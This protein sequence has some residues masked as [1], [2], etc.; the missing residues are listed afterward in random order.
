MA[1]DPNVPTTLGLDAWLARLAEP[2]GAP[3]GGSAAGVMLGLSAALL[4]MVCAYTPDDEAAAAS[5]ERVS[6]LR[7]RSLEAGR[8]DGVRSVELGAALASDGPDRSA[9]LREKAVAGAGSSAA[10]GE[11][12]LALVDELVVIA[13][14]GNPS[15]VADTGVAGE[16]LRAGLG[17]ALINLRAN[18][19]LAR[20]HSG[21]DDSSADIDE[22]AAAG[23][24][25][26][27]ARS[28]VDG[29]LAALPVG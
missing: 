4:H 19:D 20:K 5:A 15:V 10:L 28:R 14:V 26:S 29:I 17:A 8:L 16:S 23:S 22:F 1:A 11:I 2:N 21:P 24:R 18:V 25:L 27:E 6:A 13:D 7:E 3:G 12:A 9:R